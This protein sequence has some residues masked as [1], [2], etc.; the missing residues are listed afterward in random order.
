MANLD[1]LV[2]LL[3]TLL[4]AKS[5][6]AN[7]ARLAAAMVGFTLLILIGSGKY[8]P[9]KNKNTTKAPEMNFRMPIKAPERIDPWQLYGKDYFKNLEKNK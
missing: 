6:N 7:F 4:N 1:F 5:S 2:Q 3:K 8:D 9:S